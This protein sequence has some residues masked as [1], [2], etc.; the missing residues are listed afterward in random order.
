MYIYF[1]INAVFLPMKSKKC[2]IFGNFGPFFET[3]VFCANFKMLMWV[4][5]DLDGESNNEIPLHRPRWNNLRHKELS[6]ILYWQYFA[7]GSSGMQIQNNMQIVRQHLIFL[8]D[9]SK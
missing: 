7:F 9:L 8:I 4:F 1:N 5:V 2:L 6:M 3:K